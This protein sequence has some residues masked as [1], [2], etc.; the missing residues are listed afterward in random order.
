MRVAMA[1]RV[2]V[3]AMVVALVVQ[4]GSAQSSEPPVSRNAPYSV[5]VD[6]GKSVAVVETGD[7]V[8]SLESNPCAITI[9]HLFSSQIEHLLWTANYYVGS[10]VGATKC[11]LTLTRAGDLQ[12][13]ALFR[14]TNTLIWHSNTAGKG[15][16]KLALEHVFD[17]GNLQLLTAA[18]VVKY[19]SFDVKE[20]AILPT[21]KLRC[22]HSALWLIAL[23][24][25]G[26]CSQQPNNTSYYRAISERQ[27]G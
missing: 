26:Q 10:L 25:L 13:F 24:L 11:T 20:F 19:Q 7:F 17:S 2:L 5:T 27:S 18:N 3:V 23:A 6:A 8:V 1:G 21:Q 22:L 15:I 12:L 16:V 14:G 4:C 9:R